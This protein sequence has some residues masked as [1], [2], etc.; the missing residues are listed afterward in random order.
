MAR[1]F[2][3]WLDLKPMHKS[4]TACNHYNVLA[5]FK[6]WYVRI[7]GNKISGEEKQAFNI[8]Q[9]QEL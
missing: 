2:S 3:K 7:K 6:N 1:I 5:I 4:S 8:D 9:D